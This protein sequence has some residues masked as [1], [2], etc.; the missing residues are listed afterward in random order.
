MA[1]HPMT[2]E[3]YLASER[4]AEFKSEYVQGEVLQMS[5]FT[6]RHGYLVAEI[7]FQIANQLSEQYSAFPSSIKVRSPRT[8]SYLYPDA[9]VVWGPVVTFGANADVLVNPI[10]VVEVLSP[11]TAN[12]D[13]SKKFELYREIPSLADYILAAL[14]RA[15][16]GA[17]QPAAGRALA[18]LGVPG[19]GSGV[20]DRLDRV[21]GPA[22]Q[23]VLEG[24]GVPRL[25]RRCLPTAR[26]SVTSAC[27]FRSIGRSP[28]RSR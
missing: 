9:S 16:G 8:G 18:L 14:G 22:E 27:R 24:D 12:Y 1:A 26:A 17:L 10:V 11:S 6:L 21:S 23:R 3:E 25:G 7:V 4:V 28:I 19:N 5:G 15:V 20:R 2:E 13:R